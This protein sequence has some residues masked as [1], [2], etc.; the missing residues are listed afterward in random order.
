VNSGKVIDV[1]LSG[2]ISGETTVGGLVGL[3]LGTI[4]SCSTTIQVK[5]TLS[6][7]GII[8]ANADGTL[9]T[10]C[11]AGGN[12][13]GSSSVGGLIGTNKGMVSNNK[14]KVAV[15][16]DMS[17]G[18]LV[19]NNSYIVENCTAEG[20]IK[21]GIDVGG[22]VGTNMKEGSITKS[23]SG[24][25]VS[26]KR[27][28]GG[29][30]GYNSGK[31]SNCTANAN[32]RGVEH[33]VTYPEKRFPISSARTNK[34]LQDYLANEYIGA[35][36]SAGGLA[37]VSNGTIDDSSATGDV[38]GTEIVGGLVGINLNHGTVSDCKASGNVKGRD[39]V[40]GLI[41]ENRNTVANSIANGKVSADGRNV[42]QLVGYGNL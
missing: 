2:S 8:G 29:L 35:D 34:D 27:N 39:S 14:S 24:K 21:G 9:V 11:V 18:G 7:G 22:L 28:V 26:G 10:N 5:G 1:K 33:L 40:G 16:G 30:V 17:T 25:E 15:S 31:V 23:S 13:S 32:A 6:A 42:G 36:A 4:D 19:G 3:N 12:V 41:G 38:D 20:N 37:G